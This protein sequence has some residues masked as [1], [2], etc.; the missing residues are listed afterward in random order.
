MC[1]N[2]NRV[3]KR[4]ENINDRPQKNLQIGTSKIDA[5]ILPQFV[6]RLKDEDGMVNSVDPE[7]ASS[8]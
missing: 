1:A 5:V 3:Y 2:Y 7:Q 6:M 4:K 8:L